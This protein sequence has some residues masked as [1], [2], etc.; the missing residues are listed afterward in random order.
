MK[1]AA[2]AFA[3]VMAVALV[4]ASPVSPASAKTTAPA[5]S[6]ASAS[7]VRFA[8]VAG[9]RGGARRV[10]VARILR[11]R[12]LCTKD[13]RVKARF[14]LITPAGSDTV[15]GGRS[16]KAL[17]TW[18]TGMILTRTGLGVLKRNYLN[19]RMAVR[20]VATDVLTGKRIVRN[21]SYGFR[22]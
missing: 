9:P 4:P 5:E 19:S 7:A 2:L 8:L 12:V 1:K 6:G 11:F 13:C 18:H 10:K 16:L 14:K 22:K 20:F 21:R 17:V 15:K 3:A